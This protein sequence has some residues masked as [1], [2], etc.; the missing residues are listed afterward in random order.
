M[1]VFGMGAGLSLEGLLNDEFTPGDIASESVLGFVP[2]AGS[3][4]SM[5]EV[6]R[7]CF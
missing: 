7:R 1:T 3:F 5:F 2:F 6:A 4:L